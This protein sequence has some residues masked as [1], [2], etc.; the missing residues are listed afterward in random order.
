L[1]SAPGYLFTAP[2]VVPPIAAGQSHIAIFPWRAIDISQ[3][4]IGRSFLKVH[5]TPF[6]GDDTVAGLQVHENNN[7]AFKEIFFRGAVIQDSLG[8][9]LTLIRVTPVTQVVPFD[10]QIRQ[11]PIAAILQIKITATVTMADGTVAPPVF[12]S[13]PTATAAGWSFVGGA[14]SWLSLNQPVYSGSGPATLQTLTLFSGNLI[15]DNTFARLDLHVVVGPAATPDFD[16]T[17]AVNIKAELSRNSHA[18]AG[19][20]DVVFRTFANWSVLPAQTSQGRYGPLASDQFTRYRTAAMFDPIAGGTQLKAFAVTSGYGFVQEISGSSTQL[21]LILR[22]E[23]QIATPYGAVKYFVYRGLKTSSF[24]DSTGAVKADATATNNEL[25]NR[26]WAVR[27]SLNAEEKHLNPAF[28]D[29]PLIRDDIGLTSAPD[30]P[31]PDSM[32]ISE[33]IDRFNRFTRIS[34]GMWIGDFETT[35]SYGFE[36]VVEGPAPEATLGDVRTLDHTIDVPG[37]SFGNGAEDDLAT[38]LTRERILNYIDPAAFI[39]LIAGG[40]IEYSTA[41]GFNKVDSIHDVNTQVLVKFATK[42]T[43]YLDVRNELNQSLNFFG[44]YGDGTALNAAQLQFQD[45]T[46]NMVAKSYHNFGW[47]VVTL[48]TSEFATDNIADKLAVRLTLPVGDNSD[49]ILFLA[50]AAFHLDFP[51]FT[52]KYDVVTAALGPA[53]QT[54]QFDVGVYNDKTAGVILPA[55]IKIVYARR[56]QGS[57]NPVFPARRILKDDLIDTLLSPIATSLVTPPSGTTAWDTVGELRYNGWTSHNGFD[58]TVKSGRALDDFGEV[59][60]AYVKGPAEIHGGTSQLA[61]HSSLDKDKGKDKARSFYEHLQRAGLAFI[62][63]IPTNLGPPV[64]A[65]RVQSVNGNFSVNILDRSA[66]D[67]ISI[68]YTKAEATIIRGAA[69]TANFMSS[70]P[71]YF[72]AMNHEMALGGDQFPYFVMDLGLEGIVFN[73]VGN[74]YSVVQ[75]NTG[76]KVYS[77]DDRNFFSAAYTNAIAPLLPFSG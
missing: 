12:F 13:N 63:T 14:P 39:G 44:N 38:K 75:V 56:Y 68:A 76:V 42:D 77:F 32:P 1:P 2:H 50:G 67:L 64:P 62:A 52:R 23:E 69:T 19:G 36:I 24:L 4:P 21:N 8:K 49:P 15:V 25:L 41:T 7:L 60:F 71:Q 43:V 26:Y 47:P 66:D 74:T 17:L 65:L 37:Q 11:V 5:I 16:R 70:A 51:D 34:R 72:M 55:A 20:S 6:D 59:A 48:L 40:H 28:V 27:N 3:N 46:G 57:T 22:P 9:E 29:L 54:S 35:S 73:S 61:A 58:F 18:I 45:K 53:S 30:P 31:L 10:L 33:V